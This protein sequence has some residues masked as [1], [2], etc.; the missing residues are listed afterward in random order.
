MAGGTVILWLYRGGAIDAFIDIHIRWLLAR[1]TDVESSWLNRIQTT[2]VF[3]TADIVATGLAPAILG[4]VA[5]WRRDRA[6]A[7]ILVAWVG[8]TLLTVMA[9]G[10]FYPYHWHPVYPALATL[11][12]IGIGFIFQSSHRPNGTTLDIVGKAVAVAAL[13]AAALRPFIHVYRAALLAVGILSR[14][15]YDAVEFGPYGKTGVFTHLADYFRAHTSP[16]EPVLVWGSVANVYYTS[17][18]HAPTR[19]GYTAPL[20]NPQN[21]EF[22]RRYRAEFM[23]GLNARPPAYIATLSPTV[24]TY[25]RDVDQRRIIGRAEE[26]MR[27]VDELPGLAAFI[28]DRYT[29]DSTMGP[30][31]L[32]RRRGSPSRSGDGSATAPPTAPPVAR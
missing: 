32:Y 18:R 20:V 15:R 24:C 12:G 31:L 14:E 29:V 13:A 19:F 5:V 2:G 17:E 9:Q 27:C 22:R 8:G 26:R 7:A 25:A 10:N 23:A 6:Y 21:D 30:I 1:Y 11:A 16:D 28:A 3:L 4:V